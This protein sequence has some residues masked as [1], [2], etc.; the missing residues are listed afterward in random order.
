MT[1][2]PITTETFDERAATG[3]AMAEFFS[4]YHAC[5]MDVDG[6]IEDIWNEKQSLSVASSASSQSAAS[7]AKGGEWLAARGCYQEHEGSGHFGHDHIVRAVFLTLDATLRET[8]CMMSGMLAAEMHERHG[9]SFE[10][11]AREGRFT[12]ISPEKRVLK[13]RFSNELPVLGR[14]VTARR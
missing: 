5:A 7:S 8:G 14:L 9:D 13:R 3:D 2:K 6:L 1:T 4:H 11:A 12:Y 10:K